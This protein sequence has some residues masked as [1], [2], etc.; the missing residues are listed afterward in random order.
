MASTSESAHSTTDRADEARFVDDAIPLLEP[1]YR[2]ALRMTRNHVDAEDLLQE[3]MVKAY[4]GFH[5]FR[6]GSNFNAWLY[7]ILVNTYIN[8]YRR[9]QRTPAEYLTRDFTDQQLTVHATHSAT[10]LHSA[11]D[12][13]LDSMP[14]T[15][16]KAAMEALPEQFRMAVY[17]A[18]VEGLARDQIAEV[19][20]T[21]RG[22]VTSRLHRGRRQLRRLLTH[23]AA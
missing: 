13:A 17:Y 7:R 23:R 22:T 8:N 5:S 14:D 18:D 10:R 3:T 1:L 21:P 20:G 16:I 19:M 12:R 2:Q 9:Q 4:S 11:E 6:Q 15:D